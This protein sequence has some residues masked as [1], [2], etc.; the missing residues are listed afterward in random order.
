VHGKPLSFRRFNLSF[1]RI[2]M[3]N[4]ILAVMCLMYLVLYID[5]VNIATIAPRMTTDL[6]LSNTQFG[7][8]VSAFSFPY[9]LFQLFGGWISDRF[10]ARRTLAICGII[11]CIAT[12]STGFV[13]GLGSLVAARLVLGLGEGSAF[14]TAT[15]AIAVWVPPARWGLAQGIT[16]GAARLG[17]ALAPTV[18]V[19]L[20]AYVSWRGSFITLGMFSLVWIALW[21]WLYRDDPHQHTGV[22]PSE[23][24][25]LRPVGIDG[26]VNAPAVPW[27][28]LAK[29][30]APVTAVDF[31]Y[32][33]TI[34]VFLTW[35][36]TF[37]YK[38]F[39]LDLRHS[40]LFSSG[41]LLGG[42]A[43]DAAG[44]YFSDRLYRRTGSLQVARRN[45]IATGMLG[46]FCFLIPVVLTHELRPVVICLSLACFFSEMVVGP[47]WA[48]PMDI[49]PRYSGSA[50]G[51]M[52]FGFGIA[53]IL[54]PVIF[55]KVL[56]VTGS[57]AVPFYGSISLLLLGAGL[58]FFMRPDR[59][60]EE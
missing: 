54:S 29:R 33:W 42:V 41:V 6:H 2:S 8:A 57:W 51:M 10:G 7:L 43:G 55:G 3:T 34:W 60:F 31:C 27:L 50:S 16:H 38:S 32:G 58:S 30:M 49:A 17:N 37:F 1:P 5:R 14:P 23:L 35:L 18:V 48:V 53:G 4:Q 47:I 13:G 11:V 12:V 44:G 22:S 28:R 52:N 56:D 15:R 19:G 40:A 36:P 39:H 45:V 46:A 25:A 9:A 21:L 59:P 26:N 24:E 20:L